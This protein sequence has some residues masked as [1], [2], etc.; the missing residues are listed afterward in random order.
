M[1]HPEKSQFPFMINPL[2]RKKPTRRAPYV[3]KQSP[4][5][6]LHTH[7]SRHVPTQLGGKLPVE[8]FANLTGVTNVY[9]DGITFCLRVT[10]D[11]SQK[12]KF[13][14]DT[15]FQTGA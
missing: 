2:W 12:N 10:G 13:L 8:T 15:L 6:A 11:M 7:S 4:C 3:P 5:R 14:P 9:A 1:C